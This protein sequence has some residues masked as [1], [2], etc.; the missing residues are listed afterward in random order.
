MAGL[1]VET[2]LWLHAARCALG[3]ECRFGGEGFRNKGMFKLRAGFSLGNMELR[4]SPSPLSTVL[5]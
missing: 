4:T 2:A 5:F 1:I 3:A